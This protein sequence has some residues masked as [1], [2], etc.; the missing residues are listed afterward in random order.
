M[1]NTKVIIKSLTQ[2]KHTEPHD[3]EKCGT[4]IKNLYA[5]LTCPANNWDHLDFSVV[6]HNHHKAVIVIHYEYVSDYI[7][8]REYFY[9]FYADKFTWREK[10]HVR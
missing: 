8:F 4:L 10:W 9:R 2:Y 5:A 1:K 6:K 7:E 3:S